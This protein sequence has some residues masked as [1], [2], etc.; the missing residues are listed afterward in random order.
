MK[1][2]EEGM[3]KVWRC[4]EIDELYMYTCMGW[5]EKKRNG[6]WSEEVGGSV[7]VKSL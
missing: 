2:G 4:S 3:S 5:A 1:C 7:A 6:W